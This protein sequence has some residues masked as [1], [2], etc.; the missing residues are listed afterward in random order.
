MGFR[1]HA[2]R[3][4]KFQRRRARNP[5][6]RQEVSK[7][8]QS[9]AEA[10]AFPIVRP[11]LFRTQRR[12]VIWGKALDLFLCKVD[13]IIVPMLQGGTN[14]SG[15]HEKLAA[16]KPASSVYQNIC[17]RSRCLVKD[18]IV[19]LAQLLVTRSVNLGPAD[20]VGC[21]LLIRK[22]GSLPMYR[23]VAYFLLR[24]ICSHFRFASWILDAYSSSCVFA[25]TQIQR[26]TEEG[27]IEQERGGRGLLRRR[28]QG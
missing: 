14:R 21:V 8:I 2:R 18:D 15:R 13:Q 20:V 22:I 12:T 9:A 11:L 23:S 24:F 4:L 10:S 5:R 25:Q 3:E 16:G 28:S 1:K 17:D 27:L 7:T 19:D 6:P 26:E